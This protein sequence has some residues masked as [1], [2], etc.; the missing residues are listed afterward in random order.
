[1]S[2]DQKKPGA[3][4]PVKSTWT[5]RGLKALG[6]VMVIGLV[7][8]LGLLAAN[9]KWL[10]RKFHE[11]VL[12]GQA[13]QSK[14]EKQKQDLHWARKVLSGGYI[15][16]FRHAQREKW[17]DAAAF[18]AYELATSTNGADASF[19]RATCLT[20]QGV[21]EA[22]LIGNVFKLVGAKVSA[23]FSSP[24]CR[25]WQTALHAFGTDYK[26]VNSLLTRTAIIPEQRADFAK[27]LRALLMSIE[28]VPGSNVVL[29]GHGS[30]FKGAGKAALDEDNTRKRRKRLETGFIVLEKKDGR[31]IAQYKFTSI[32]KFA[33][34]LI[35]LPVK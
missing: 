8:G 9:G 25:A 11:A 17:H 10:P 20:P 26:I 13:H 35:E 5:R 16:H 14:A 12:G 31:I 34:A 27:E 32:K 15:L 1:M 18:D 2:A 3:R 19:S 7:F 21:E 33:N 29:T 23:V 22:R 28:I 30:P 4:A 6:A 24:S